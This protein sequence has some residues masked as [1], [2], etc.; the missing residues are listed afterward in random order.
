MLQ[1]A[2][3]LG[4]DLADAFAGHGELLADLFQRVIGVHA[5]AE[6]IKDTA[7]AQPLIVA[8]GL[9]SARALNISG[10]YSF[11]AGHSV[12][13]ITAA[14]LAGVITPLDAMNKIS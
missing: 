5:D 10:K 6:E 7:N 8:A 12:G 3:R 1:L 14:A 2:Q 11:V 9:L 13:E 4:L